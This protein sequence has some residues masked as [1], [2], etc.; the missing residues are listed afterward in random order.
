MSD[1]IIICPY[2]TP[3][4]KCYFK[5]SECKGPCPV[6]VVTNRKICSTKKKGAEEP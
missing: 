1:N 3:E 4:M 2:V 5:E 6:L